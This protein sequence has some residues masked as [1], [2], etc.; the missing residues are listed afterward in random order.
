M[1]MQESKEHKERHKVTGKIFRKE[2]NQK[3]GPKGFFFL[4]DGD[5]EI[6]YT[7]WSQSI[8]DKYEQDDEVEIVY[9]LDEN[10]YNGRVFVNKVIQN[11]N[12]LNRGNPQLTED[13]YKKLEEIGYKGNKPKAERYLISQNGVIKL[14]GLNY[15]IKEIEVELLNNDEQ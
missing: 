14:G 10:E 8:F 6:K 9:V 13:N 7:C 15:R 3:K 1:E 12:F 11:M 4:M 5:K 2:A